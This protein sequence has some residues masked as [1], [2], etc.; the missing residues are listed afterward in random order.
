MFRSLFGLLTLLLLGTALL[1]AQS[2]V[3]PASPPSPALP[4]LPDPAMPTG[5]GPSAD[6]LPPPPDVPGPGTLGPAYFQ[7]GSAYPY[8]WWLRAECLIWRVKDAPAPPPLA[9]TGPASAASPAVLGQPGTEVLL[10]GRPIDFGTSA[11]GRWTLGTWCNAC[12]D[13]GW[14]FTGLLVDPPPQTP[15]VFSNQSGLPILGRPFFAAPQ[16]TPTTDYAAFPNRF[17]GSIDMASHSRLWGLETLYVH[18]WI[19]WQ[20]LHLASCDGVY[21]LDWLAGVRYLDLG[22]DLGI[23]QQSGILA[24]GIANFQG[25]TVGPGNTI[26]VADRFATRNQFW[27][28]ETGA[29]AEFVWGAFFLDVSTKLAAGNTRE[30]VIVNGASAVIPPPSFMAPPNVVAGGLLATSTNIGTRSRDRFTVVPEA[31]INIGYQLFEQVRFYAGYTFLYWSSVV[32]PGNQIDPVVNLTQVPIHPSYG[33]LVGPAR[34]A[35]LFQTTDFWAQGVNL[36]VELR[37]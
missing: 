34:P 16:A 26:F 17:A 14:E 4:V 33:P 32:R 20:S 19:P 18:N 8:L 37:F 6:T 22:E 11:G 24:G 29:R 7:E 31:G 1:P 5:M 36:G 27:G 15:A 30:T 28:G 23:A 35:P 2:P 9:T 12:Q 3:V 10:G 21:R 13:Y 25:P